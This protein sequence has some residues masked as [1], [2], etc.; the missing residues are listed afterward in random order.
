MRITPDVN[1]LDGLRAL[2]L[3]WAVAVKELVDNAFDA[4]AKTILIEW[5][6]TYSFEISDDGIGAD[7]HGVRAM[8]IMGR[9][10]PHARGNA[11]GR[12]G[13]GAKDALG[14][15]WGRT[16]VKTTHKKLTRTVVLN[17]DA[18]MKS[19]AWEIDDPTVKVASGSHQHGTIISVSKSLRKAPRVDTCE[20]M[21]EDLGF[22][23][24]PALTSGATI[25]MGLGGKCV[26]VAAFQPPPV[27]ADSHIDVVLKVGRK[28]ARVSAWVVP[29]E[30]E[31]RKFGFSYVH[32][33][34]VILPSSNLGCGEYNPSRLFG[35]VELVGDEWQLTRHK[36]AIAEDDREQL[37]EKVYEA[38]E[39]LLKQAAGMAIYVQ[40]R[41]IELDL[42]KALRG[43]IN[44]IKEKRN[45]KE[46][47]TGGAKPAHSGKKRKRA[48]KVSPHLEGSVEERLPDA[49]ALK[50]HFARFG[51]DFGLG[52]YESTTQTVFLNEDDTNIAAANADYR[53][54]GRHL[55]VVYALTLMCYEVDRTGMGGQFFLRDEGNMGFAKTLSSLLATQTGLSIASDEAAA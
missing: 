39:H 32:R 3:T 7:E 17:W 1:M 43:R 35:W 29:P 36:D 6:D 49:P 30:C 50:V 24:A 34:R 19:G 45:A 26:D 40:L 5:P 12:F 10:R 20:R 48:Q 13:V 46:N 37:A 51:V 55:L 9:H 23:Y 38:T 41:D 18:L 31:N 14:W 52:K 53:R 42:A 54:S 2:N 4:D 33:H 28:E 44:Q 15:M 47:Q 16:V 27:L 8:L 22:T 25:S 21:A 11:L